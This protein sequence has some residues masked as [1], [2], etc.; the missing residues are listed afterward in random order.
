MRFDG[1]RRKSN[2]SIRYNN[3]NG[4]MKIVTHVQLIQ[5]KGER[6]TGRKEH[7]TDHFLAS[8]VL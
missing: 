1:K 6:A 2:K 5:G 4:I 8:N 3:V 7:R